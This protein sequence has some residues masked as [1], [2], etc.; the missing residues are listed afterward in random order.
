MTDLSAAP[1]ANLFPSLAYA[2]QYTVSLWPASYKMCRDVTNEDRKLPR[3][4][5]CQKET[6][7]VGRTVTFQCLYKSAVIGIVDQNA[8][9]GRDDELCAVR[10]PA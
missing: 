8:V 5:K 4:F 6:L 7:N 2:T 10:P 9:S 3:S 1:D